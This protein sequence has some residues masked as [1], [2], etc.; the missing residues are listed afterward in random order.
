MQVGFALVSEQDGPRRGGA[1]GRPEVTSHAEIEQAGFRLFADRGF[2]RT[3]LTDIA[4]EVGVGRRTLFRYFA[5]KNDIPWG[6]FA[7]T[8]AHFREVLD[9]TPTDIAVHEA[10]ERGVLEFNRFPENA[11][12]SHRDRM[13]LILTTPELQAHSVLQYAAWRGVIAEFVARRVGVE[14]DDLLPRLVGHVS[15]A[16]ALASYEAWLADEESD[17]QEIL[18]SSMTTLGDYLST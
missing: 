14:P 6:Q 11:H 7:A 2:A 16:L 12:P 18:A 1:R 5:S 17:L 3:T 15:L 8:L 9:G 13:R 10:V 4:D